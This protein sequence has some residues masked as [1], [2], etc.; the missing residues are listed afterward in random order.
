MLKAPGACLPTAKSGR[1]IDSVPDL[2]G[3]T[4]DKI[5]PRT[6]FTEDRVCACRRQECYGSDG[7]VS[8]KRPHH[9]V[10]NPTGKDMQ[11]RLNPSTA[12]IVSW[13]TDPTVQIIHDCFN[14]DGRLVKPV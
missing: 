4:T 14:H 5:L 1:G 13:A 2:I 3:V 6:K 7:Q 8:V 10:I 12:R 11:L 9:E